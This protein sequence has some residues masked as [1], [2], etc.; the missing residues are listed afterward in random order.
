MPTLLKKTSPINPISPIDSLLPHKDKT[1]KLPKTTPIKKLKFSHKSS[2]TSNKNLQLLKDPPT[3]NLKTKR[4]KKIKSLS[5]LSLKCLIKSVS[6]TLVRNFIQLLTKQ[7]KR[8]SIK[9]KMKS[10]GIRQRLKKKKI[11]C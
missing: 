4:K 8:L 9:C 10:E 1:Q 6:K 11:H 5:F 3:K 2:K 7:S